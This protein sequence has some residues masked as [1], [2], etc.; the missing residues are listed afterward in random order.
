VINSSYINVGKIVGTSAE[1]EELWAD[2]LGA[3]TIATKLLDA[4]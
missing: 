1:F 4:D 2:N 3:N